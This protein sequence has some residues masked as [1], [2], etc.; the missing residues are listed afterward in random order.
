MLEFDNPVSPHAGATLSI[1]SDTPSL[2]QIVS[3]GETTF[4]Y[5]LRHVLDVIAG[6]A[7]PLTG[8]EDARQQHA[9]HRCHLPRRRPAAARTRRL[10]RESWLPRPVCEKVRSRARPGHHQLA[11]AD[12]R[13]SRPGRRAGAARIHAVLS[14]TRLGRTRRARDLGDAARHHVR[15]AARGA[16]HA[17][18]HRRG[19]HQQSARDHGVVGPRHG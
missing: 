16:P 10:R 8:G 11:F 5:Q 13:R 18:R 12:L 7:Q 9:R 14:A 15:G 17:A 3:G 2:P 19:R 1:E 6:R 4:H